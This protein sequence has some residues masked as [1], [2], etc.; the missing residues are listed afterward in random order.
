MVDSLLYHRMT[1]L[2]RPMVSAR[3]VVV[4]VVVAE[5]C[6]AASSRKSLF[7]KDLGRCPSG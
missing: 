5:T 2:G 6:V 4:T 3:L 7:Y 1:E